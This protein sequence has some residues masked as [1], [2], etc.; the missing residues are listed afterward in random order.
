MGEARRRQEYKQ[1]C[2]TT[3]QEG[4]DMALTDSERKA[5]VVLL[6]EQM[7]DQMRAEVRD[8]MNNEI[9]ARADAQNTGSESAGPSGD[10]GEKYNSSAMKEES[11]MDAVMKRL[12]MLHS[13]MDSLEERDRAKNEID[14]KDDFDEDGMSEDF[15]KGR[16]PGE[17]KPLAADNKDCKMD[18]DFD[19]SPR[20]RKLRAD[21]L[22]NQTRVRANRIFAMMNQECPPPF[23]DE[24]G[25]TYRKRVLN[26]LKHFSPRFKDINLLAIADADTFRAIE[27]QVYADADQAVRNPQT[28][29][30]KGDDL[31][32]VTEVDE[33]GRKIKSFYGE[34][35]AWMSY[36]ST[37][38]RKLGGIRTA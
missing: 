26:D 35:R 18:S 5:L 7:A 31:R 14:P 22:K 10:A 33:S 1:K 13:K 38:A 34:P 15:K 32:E 37:P 36:F 2:I 21:A 19:S 8:F 25:M 28:W 17:P 29:A 23:T 3:N 4:N 6:R 27:D 24:G 11:V 12:D 16:A 20:G 30:G 9:K